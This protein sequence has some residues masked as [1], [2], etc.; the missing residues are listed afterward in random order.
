MKKIYF[1]LIYIAFFCLCSTST[2]QAQLSNSQKRTEQVQPI[3]GLRVYPN[4]VLGNKLYITSKS[5]KSKIVTIFNVL[6]EKV[7]FEV[8]TTN[9]LDISTLS[10]GIYV[11]QVKEKEKT[12]LRKL[13]VK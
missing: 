3:D 13:V 5:G 8:M 11:V 1:T 12:A 4:P 7:L 9:E 2:V 10:P 6:G